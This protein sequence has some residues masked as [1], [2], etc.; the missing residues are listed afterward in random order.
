L[1]DR[2]GI[3][4]HVFED[5]RA[6]FDELVERHHPATTPESAPLVER[7]CAQARAENRAA[8]AQL[9]AIGELFA[10]RLSRC[11]ETEEW[12][13]DTMQA[14][15]HPR[16]QP[17]VLLPHPSRCEDVSSLGSGDGEEA[18]FAGDALEL[19]RSAV[20]KFKS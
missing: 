15:A 6:R 7:I 4:E 3:R 20:F 13:I 10:Y 11:A 2:R 19:V 18:P 8:A 14:V 16:G 5:V 17:Q 9:V 12:A 1:P